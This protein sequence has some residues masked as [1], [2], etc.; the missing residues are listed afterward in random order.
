MPLGRLIGH[1]AVVGFDDVIDAL[2]ALDPKPRERQWSSLWY[3][4]I[5]AVWSISARYDQVVVPLVRRVAERTGDLHPVVAVPAALPPDPL[6]LPA[7]LVRYPTAVKLRTDTNGQRTSTR[8]GIEKADAAL[9][10]ARILIDH[11]TPDLSTVTRIIGNH[12]RFDEVNKALA[13][14]PGEG[15]AGVRRGYLWM[16]AGSD[17]LSKPDRMI[18]RWLARHGHSATP[19][20]ARDILQQAAEELTR[21]LNRPV[22]PWMVDH[23]IWLTRPRAQSTRTS[24]HVVNE[25]LGFQNPQ[26]PLVGHWAGER[27]VCG[28]LS[29]PHVAG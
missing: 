25:G 7:L 5:D 14:V 6:P 16:L 28:G 22:T 10:Y 24:G 29:S 15:S 21:R 19:A 3:C 13:A 27:R 20:Q 11:E 12:A 26:E 17:D 2:A 23:A 8:G 9:R 4:V 18:L 1:R